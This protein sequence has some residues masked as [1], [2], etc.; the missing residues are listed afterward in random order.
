MYQPATTF[1][2]SGAAPSGITIAYNRYHQIGI[3]YAQVIADFNIRAE[4]AANITEDLNGDDGDIYNPSIAWSLGFDRD[5]VWGI[6]LNLQCNESIRLMDDEVSD[7]PLVDTEAGKDITSTL[8]TAALSKKFPRDELELKTTAVWEIENGA[9]LIMPAIVWTKND[10][11]LELS[12]GIFAGGDE[13]LFGQFQD[14]SFV[15]VG[16]KYTF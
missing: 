8:I 14:N 16:L 13:G 1:I 5:L 10:V 12:G 7:D 4:A 15:R 11:A 2:F 9:A 3:D 6:N